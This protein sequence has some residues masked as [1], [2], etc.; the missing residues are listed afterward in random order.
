M[1]PPHQ[2]LLL[3]SRCKGHALCVLQKQLIHA[4]RLHFLQRLKGPPLPILIGHDAAILLRLLSGNQWCGVGRTIVDPRRD[5]RNDRLW[6]LRAAVWHVRFFGMVDQR[7]QQTALRLERHHDRAMGATSQQ[8]LASRHV[9]VALHFFAAVALEAVL[10][11]NRRHLAVE[12][13]QAALHALRMIRR[14]SESRG[15]EE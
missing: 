14:Q 8:I 2:H 10:F 9:E 11:Q 7:H 3:R 4:L 12:E 15:R 5:L 1:Q 6:Q 13:L